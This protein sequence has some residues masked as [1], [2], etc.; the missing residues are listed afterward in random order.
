MKKNS[1]IYI[2]EERLKDGYLHGNEEI[3]NDLDLKK[4]LI[5]KGFKNIVSKN[6]FFKDEGFYFFSG[7]KE[8]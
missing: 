5:Q 6:Y 3:K 2:G 8:V 1:I 7:K 4:I